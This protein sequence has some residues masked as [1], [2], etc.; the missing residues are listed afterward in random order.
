MRGNKMSQNNQVQINDAYR[1]IHRYNGSISNNQTKIRNLDNKI[2]RLT[3]VKNTIASEKNS[4]QTEKAKMR[5]NHYEVE[6]WKGTNMEA[7][8]S[9]VD[10]DLIGGYAQY[11]NHVDVVHDEISNEI[12]RLENEKY[13]L[14]GT[15]SWLRSKINSLFNYIENCMN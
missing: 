4:I 11:Y 8:Q 13:Q 1:D 12:T 15:I 10:T 9:G 3:H 5:P 6:K 2:S 7:Y 14:E